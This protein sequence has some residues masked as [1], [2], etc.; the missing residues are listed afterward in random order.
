MPKKIKKTNPFFALVKITRPLNLFQA[1]IAVLV[2]ASIMN[3]FPHWNLIFITIS[4]ACC[5]AAAGNSINDYFDAEIDKINRPYRPIPSG[6]ISKNT[7]IF[8]TI[9][10]FIIGFYLSIPIFTYTTGFI[11]ISTAIL[12]IA[13]TPIFKPTVF[14]G[15]FIVSTILG[16]TFI[17]S[18]SIFGDIT[19]GIPPAL[20]AFGFNLARELIKDIED[21]E[22]DISRNAKTIPIKYGKEFAKKLSLFLLIILMIG[23]F[24]PSIMNIYSKYYLICL[25]STV[26][27]PLIY[28][29]FLVQNSKKKQDYSRISNLLKIIIFFGL[30]S[31]YAG[32]F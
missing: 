3:I 24:L 5:F 20:L 23:A 25:I 16:T 9:I 18:A 32:Q 13:Y 26:E 22:G 7:A 10:C 14:M 28:V 6:S 1:S 11:L 4:I 15:N 8:F 17:F 31:I 21:I 29:L 12:L 30:L 2:T 19:K 27:I